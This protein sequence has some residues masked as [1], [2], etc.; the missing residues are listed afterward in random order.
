VTVLALNSS[1]TSQMRTQTWVVTGG[2][3]YVGSHITEAFVR[4]GMQVVV[5]D[6][7]IN[8]LESRIDYLEHKY[9]CKIPMV[10]EDVRNLAKI[11]DTFR[12]FRPHGVI[13]TAALKSVSESIRDPKTYMEVNFHGTQNVLD[14]MSKLEIRNMIFSS[15]AAVYGLPRTQKMIKES[16]DTNPISPYG[17][18]KLFAEGAVN[19]FLSDS[20]NKGTSLRFFNVVGRGSIELTDYS[21]DNL[22]PII[23]KRLEDGAPIEI[24]GTDYETPDG[25][26][27]RDYVDVRDIASA[28]LS[29]ALNLE[30]TPNIV[31]VGTGKGVSVREMV[32]L[33]LNQ[34]NQS[35]IPVIDRPRRAGDAGF[36]CADTDLAKRTLRIKCEHSLADSIRS[37][38]GTV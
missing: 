28:H 35:K 4:A 6:S 21:I 19:K 12:K 7:L 38:L 3:G 17:Q 5:Y 25:T 34:C 8:G 27:I 30:R 11:E 31:N 18:S 10:N 29:V 32:E 14:V 1:Y 24:F 16:D 37:I 13:H 26:C 9:E 23:M 2:A 33:V 22:V 20:K 36:V 15:T